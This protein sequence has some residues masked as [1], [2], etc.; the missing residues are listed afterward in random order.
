MSAYAG[1]P[2]GVMVRTAAEMAEVLA[3]NPYSKMPGNRTVAYFLDGKPSA[4]ALQTVTN[5]TQNSFDW[6]TRN[7][8]VLSRWPWAIRS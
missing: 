1:K 4:D 5:Q 7:L 2:V 8:R 3:R 6:E